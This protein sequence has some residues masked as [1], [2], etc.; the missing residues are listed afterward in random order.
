M[1]KP[2]IRAVFKRELRSWFTNPTS[3]IFI[4]LFVLAASIAMFGSEAFFVRNLAT[5]DT[6]TQWFPIILLFFIPALTMGIWANERAN[7]TQELLLTLPAR[8]YQVV[9]GKYLAVAAIYTVSLLFTIVLPAYLFYLGE[10]DI[11]LLAST[12]LGYWLLGLMLISAAML[13]SLMFDNLAVSFVLGVLACVVLLYFG[14]ALQ[15]I[16]LGNGWMVYGPRGIFADLSRGVLAYSAFLLFFGWTAAFLYLNLVALQVRRQRDAGE[17]V[18]HRFLRFGAILVAFA[19]LT[20]W[21][22]NHLP[23]SDITQER[24]HSL[25][26]ETSRLLEEIAK[27]EGERKVLVQAF[28]SEEV[29]DGL[30][31]T[32]RSLLDLLKQYDRIGGDNVAVRIV[33]TEAFTDEADEAADEYGINGQRVDPQNP[34]PVF[35]GFAA[36]CGTEEVTVP[37]LMPG[38]SVEY[39]LTRSI[40]T[41]ANVERRVVGILK[42]EVEFQGGMDF[43]TMQQRP[44]WPIVDELKLQYEVEGAVS[45][46]EDYP[47]SLSVLLVPM[48]SSLTQP[49]MDRL[50]D[51]IMAGNKAILLDDPMPFAAPGTSATDPKGGPQNPMMRQQQP[52]Q[53][54]KGDVAGF[55]RQLDIDYPYRDIVFDA[56]APHAVIDNGSQPELVFADAAVDEEIR[57]KAG[58]NPDSPITKDLR[59]V[60][61]IFGGYCTEADKE[62][63]LTFTP[64][65][66]TSG[67]LSGVLPKA[68]A[69]T[70]NPIF[71]PQL[72]PYRPH[73]MDTDQYA[74]GCRVSGSVDGADIDVV[75]FAD[76]DMISSQFFQ[77]AKSG[78]L[79]SQ[80]QIRFDNVSL[81]HNCI[82]ELVGD[83][84]FIE[85]RSRHPKHHT[86][87]R[88]EREQ[89][90]FNETLLEEKDEAEKAAK[91][92]LDAANKRL[93]D[94]V[95]AIDGDSS[96][97]A[98]SKAVERATAQREEQRRV[99]RA[100]EQI[101]QEKLRRIARAEKD[102]RQDVDALRAQTKLASM[103]SAP[104]PALI[105]GLIVLILRFSRANKIVPEDRKRSVS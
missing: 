35:L 87:T 99:D 23:Q 93:T 79:E 74:M 38:M 55:L 81:I 73:K 12:Y 97:D 75:F 3:Y 103:A 101:E 57:P 69:F 105:V 18:L 71:G 65:I 82:D 33:P 10:P 67:A 76:L 34:D 89:R 9:L 102:R 83:S 61:S 22:L 64:L 49:Q 21:G 5:L 98:Q 62:N 7:G 41:V 59:Q 91:E 95:A 52:P 60:V 11:G 86:L 50:R 94:R 66:R 4:V 68:Q 15:A 37:F 100:S 72:N 31:R 39:E 80:Y 104:L 58:L 51:Y 46:D 96:L 19:S 30:V 16:G 56:Y 92:A 77:L 27:I 17:F 8:D 24:I 70:N 40:R 53:E 20:I 63:D 45:P 26:P 29:P 25:S 47:E 84:S 78:Q 88:I 13:G 48:V 32:R 90:E 2:I 6:L 85:L 42:T 43:Q 54:Q 44:N 36:Q 14:F 1:P 28:V